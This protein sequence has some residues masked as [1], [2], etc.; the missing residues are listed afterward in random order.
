M[1]E[2]DLLDEHRGLMLIANQASWLRL[3]KVIH[4]VAEHSPLLVGSAADILCALAYTARKTA[5]GERAIIESD[6]R[7]PLAGIRLGAE[8]SWPVLLIYTK[9]L[10]ESLS[11]LD[12]TKW[13][14]AIIYA[15]E[16]VIEDALQEEFQE[17]SAEMLGGRSIPNAV[18]ALEAIDE[19]EEV[20]LALE[21]RMRKLQLPS[22]IC[23][24]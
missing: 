16:A 17:G 10:R 11:Y 4:D 21:P 12:H 3:N 15:L 6:A 7:Q 13:H 8:I 20:Y 19:L 24:A 5:Q 14:Q 22:L 2:Y 1:F 9:V 18:E 23:S